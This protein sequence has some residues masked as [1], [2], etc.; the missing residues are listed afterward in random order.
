MKMA[1]KVLLLKKYYWVRLLICCT[2]SVTFF[3][4][5]FT[6]SFSSN[7]TKR[8]SGAN[9]PANLEKMRA[10]DIRHLGDA[11]YLDYTG[12][13]VYNDA[14][15][16]LYQKNLQ[17]HFY[18]LEHPIRSWRTTAGQITDE[19]RLELL[20]FFG[21]DPAEYSVV[22]VASATQA[23]K[24]VGENFP[25]TNG[26]I[27]AYA[28][29]NHNS[30]LGI[31]RYV[32][33]AGGNFSVV[34]WP[35]SIDEI[36]KIPVREGTLNLLAFPFQDNFAGTKPSPEFLRA[37]T[38]DRELRSKWIILGDIAAYAPTNPL[39]LTQ[40]PIDAGVISFYKIFGYPNTG[41]LII[42]NAFAKR[43][44]KR[45]FGSNSVEWS[46]LQSLEYSL[47]KSMPFRL[48]DDSVPLEMNLAVRYGLNFLNS[49]GM[50]NVRTHVWRL[51]SRLYT[52]LKDV[53]HS[54]GSRFVFIYGEHAKQNPDLQGGVV[55]FN[56]K[57]M[58]GSFFGYSTVVS[59]ASAANFHLRGGCHCNPGA[60]FASMGIPESRVK[61]YF[62]AKTTC[63]DALDVIDGIPLGSVRASIGWATTERDID[64]FA[65]W[66]QE[67]YA[68]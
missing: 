48:E 54:S 30:V 51:T 21:A 7:A 10:S 24:L 59:E 14:A 68:F 35:I 36:R 52:K 43:L 5:L 27:F 12:A 67:N 58:N 31:R 11:V 13:G 46:S 50:K 1:M 45:T 17:S 26:S 28:S 33:S 39:N 15:F 23:L 2:L 4:L 18:P 64:R 56:L 29:V 61:Q 44:Q 62:D 34:K 55:A 8:F 66:V 42:R 49:I 40:Y 19:I 37:L 47:H 53:K 16:D 63:G 9:Y 38:A 65:K 3:A 6:T 60:C 22:F 25:F 20:E 57:R 41:A 32:L